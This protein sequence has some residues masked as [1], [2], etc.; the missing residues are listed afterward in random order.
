MEQILFVNACMR[1]PEL[2]RT[3]RLSQTFLSACRARWPESEIIERDVTVC[4]LPVL[5]GP[6]AE[7]RERRFAEHPQDPMFDPAW[8]MA[9][10]DLVVVA[11]PHW[12]LTFPAALKIYLEWTSVA[13]ITFR[14][15]QQGQEGLCR[16]RSLVFLTTAG[17]PVTGQNY[18]FEY[19]RRLG[20]MF[21]IPD[22]RCVTAEGLDIWGNDSEAILRDAEERAVW[23]V[24]GL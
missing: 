19:L 2:S 15:T 18:G 17:G 9:E 14:C 13:G 8:E 21:G 1:G 24:R 23:L 4:S 7:E 10:A 20:Q 5:T 12:D 16:A 6:L 11:A 3:W 22:A